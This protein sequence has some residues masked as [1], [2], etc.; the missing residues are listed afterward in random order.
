VHVEADGLVTALGKLAANSERLF[1]V[2]CVFKCKEKRVTINTQSGLALYR[3]TQESIH[4][5]IKH[6]KASRVEVELE[7]DDV[8]FS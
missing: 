3:I 4:N 5:A 1:G 2:E 7:S 6:G 8:Q